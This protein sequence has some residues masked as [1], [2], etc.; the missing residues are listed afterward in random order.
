MRSKFSGRQN[1]SAQKMGVVLFAG[2]PWILCTNIMGHWF[3]AHGIC[4]LPKLSAQNLL[5]AKFE[6]SES[7]GCYIWAL[8]ICGLPKLSTILC[9]NITGRW[10][11]A[12]GICGSPNLSAQNLLVAIFE[13]SES[14]GCQNWALKYNRLLNLSAQNLQVAKFE[15]SESVGCQIWALRICG[16]PKLSA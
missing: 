9:T 13:R 8:R 10:F 11:W 14:A 12:H 1:L 6:R 3:W 4:G 15:R 2:M 16:L 7:A 5:V